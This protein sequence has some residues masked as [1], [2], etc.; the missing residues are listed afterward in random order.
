LES[1]KSLAAQDFLAFRRERKGSLH[2]KK[3]PLNKK[4]FFALNKAK[5][6]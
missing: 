3:T 6:T 2:S 4:D 1:V 5:N